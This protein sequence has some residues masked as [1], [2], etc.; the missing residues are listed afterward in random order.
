MQR[1]GD[2]IYFRMGGGR[3]VTWNMTALLFPDHGYLSSI[4]ICIFSSFRFRKQSCPLTQ[5]K[6]QAT[7]CDVS[8]AHAN[9]QAGCL[10]EPRGGGEVVQG[11]QYRHL[12]SLGSS[13]LPCTFHLAVVT[14][15]TQE[16]EASPSPGGSVSRRS[17]GQQS[18]KG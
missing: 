3:M 18:F 6:R 10:A 9:A 16:T 12:A 15:G 14:F 17:C 13:P 5:N 11:R 2:H 4:S 7:R 1:A 8:H